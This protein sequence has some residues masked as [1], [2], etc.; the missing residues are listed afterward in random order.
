MNIKPYKKNA[1]KH[2]DKQLKQI[3]ASIQE[4]GWQQPIVVDKNG[5]IIV[6]HGRWA[7]Y[8]KYKSEYKLSE[9]RIETA[10]LTEKQAKAYRLADNKLNESDWDMALVIDELKEL[11]VNM[12]ELTGFDVELTLEP[13]DRDDEVPERPEEP[14]AQLGDL[15]QLGEHRLLCGDATKIDDVE[16]LMDG[17]R[18]DMVFTDPPYGVDYQSNMRTKTEKFDVIENDG[19]FL[20][21]WVAPVALNSR[22]WVFV[23]TT[24]RVLDKWLP[25]VEQFGDITNMVVWHKGGGG[26]GDLKKT[27]STDYE[28]AIVCNRGAEL[29][30]KRIGSVWKL[31]K[32]FAGDYK[33]PTQKPVE[34]AFEA[35]EKTT[36]RGNLILDVFGG[37][38]STLIAAEKLGRKCYMMELDP[39]YIDVIVKRWEDY[40]GER[41]VKLI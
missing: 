27:F 5:V 22:G 14:K 2:P 18:A 31:K 3:A 26:I 10:D 13:E 34:L 23:W 29:K 1:K 15:Y 8:Q 30:G 19:V 21:D 4:F 6:G 37:S 28:V 11:D 40:T 24:W 25:I 17:Q 9:P 39:I 38:G 35:M 7:A 41:A 20:T 33:H 36:E 32:D 12:V 16:R